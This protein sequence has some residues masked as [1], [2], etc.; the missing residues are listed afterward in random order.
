MGMIY[1]DTNIAIYSVEDGGRRGDEARDAFARADDEFVVTPLVRMECLVRPLRDGN[2]SLHDEYVRLF[3][4]MPSLALGERQFE[5]ATEIRAH[6]GVKTIDA[7]HL[8]AAQTHGCKAFWTNDERLAKAA[9][10]LEIGV[11]G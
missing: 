2:L 1:I 8:A 5:R 7:L 11:I 10:G 9:G 6:F 3:D 4:R